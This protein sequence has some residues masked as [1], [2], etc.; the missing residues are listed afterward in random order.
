LLIH[1]PARLPRCSS[2]QNMIRD[3]VRET[4]R[5]AHN[6]QPALERCISCSVADLAADRVVDDICPAA[7]R[8]AS[9][10]RRNPR[11]GS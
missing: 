2:D 11:S 8:F 10:L 6:E 5:E 9:R 1:S 3:E 7:V 4:A